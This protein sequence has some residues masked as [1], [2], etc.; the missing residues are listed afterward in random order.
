MILKT[1]E[2]TNFR[3]YESE[4]I[5]FHEKINILT[6]KNAQGKTNMIEAVN[7]L[8]LGKS[9]RTRKEQELV[10]FGAGEARVKGV[11]EKKDRPHT[12][13][14]KLYSG[15]SGK[16]TY[17]V[18][19]LETKTVSDLLGGVYTIVFSPEDLRIVKGEPEARRRFLDREIILQRPLY[20]HKLKRYRDA[21]KTRN[22]LLKRD[23]V[24][25]DLLDVYDEQLSAAAAEVMKERSIW[26]RSLSAAAESAGLMI[27]GGSE[28][29][30][31]KYKPHFAWM[32]ET[33]GKEGNYAKE[34][35]LEAM[36][37]GRERDIL[38]RS[39]ESGPH[40]DDFAIYASGL[41]LR[42][43]GSQGQQRTAA[44]SLRLAERELIKKETGEDAILLLDDV[45][46]ELDTNRQERLLDSFGENQI[47]ITA[48]GPFRDEALKLRAVKVMRIENGKLDF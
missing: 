9:F 19:G 26:L 8:A 17:I 10:R 40:R 36:L 39:T 27:T 23:K 7:L 30:N 33:D 35:I 12:T 48:A 46:S 14:I 34:A 18:N 4:E 22:A 32:E 42:V 15:V 11:F 45:M 24:L 29:L 47:F 38:M 43:Y 3:N 37:K 5:V 16:K 21:L 41:D 44:L 13:E 28:K 31:V 2:M 25:Y 6:G 20:Y 1:L